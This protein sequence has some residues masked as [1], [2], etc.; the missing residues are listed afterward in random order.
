MSDSESICRDEWSR[1]QQGGCGTYAHALMMERPG[2]RLG[3]VDF[4]P[5]PGYDNPTHFVA[6][7]GEYAYDSAGRHRLPYGGIEGKGKWLPDIGEPEHWGIPEDEAEYGVP[8]ED[9]YAAAVAHIRCHRILD[10]TYG[11]TPGSGS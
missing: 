10:G 8:D 6:H 2:L 11:T 3:G 7:D 5:E 4:W 9:R 1:W